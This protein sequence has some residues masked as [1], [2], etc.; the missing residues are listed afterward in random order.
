MTTGRARILF[1]AEAVTLA[2]VGRMLSLA[3]ALDSRGYEVLVASDPRYRAAIGDVSVPMCDLRTI[4][5]Q[6][7]FEA[8]D[9]G[10]PIYSWR[11]LV[12]YV[13]DDRRVIR[14]QRPDVV[15]G[16]FRLSL[17]ASARLEKVPYVTLTNAYW[18]P[19][20]E[21]DFVVPDIP[22]TRLLG[23]TMGQRL[24]DLVRPLAFAHHAAPVNRM[25]RQFKLPPGPRDLRYAYTDADYTLYSDIREM[26][27][28]RPLPGHHRFVGPVQWAPNLP[29][30]TWWTEIPRTKPILYV[31]FG[32]SGRGELLSAILG[33][34]EALPVTIVAAT[35]GRVGLPRSGR[36]PFVA[37]YLPG[38]EAVRLASIVVCNG[39]SPSCYQALTAGKP[40]IGLPTNLDQY[41]NMSLV[42]R[43]G[44]GR[45]IRR[46]RRLGRDIVAAVTTMLETPSFAAQARVLQDRIERQS[47]IDSVQEVLEHAVSTPW[48]GRN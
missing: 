29:V 48:A 13:D 47:P 4:P 1:I 45:L 6:Q 34:L 5:S 3:H 26:V 11:D 35:A 25:L 30:P 18:S 40:V 44:A 42:E 16:D 10:R 9:A 41:L 43:V 2:H 19:Y 37:D 23:V 38:D 36:N 17:A 12:R 24:F 33:A 20:A 15:V 8:L 21:I 14:E 7:F 28:T 32:S 31:N 27:P 46:S 39:G 22:A